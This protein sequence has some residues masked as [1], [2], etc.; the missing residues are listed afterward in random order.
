MR[1]RQEQIWLEDGQPL[2]PVLDPWQRTDFEALDQPAYQH[3]YLERPRGHS[4]TGD[5]G[6]EAVVEL[7]LGRAGQQLIAVAADE[8]QAR[9]LLDDVVAKFRRNPTLAPLATVQKNRVVMKHGGST[10][11]VLASDAPSSY[12]L[13][14]DWICCDE[15]AEWKSRGLWD[16]LWSAT[17]KRASCRVLVISTAGWDRTSI[18]WEV[19][20]I[21]ETEPNWYFS[22]RGQCASWVRPAWLAQQQRTL[23]SHVF[24]RLHENR[25]VDHVGAFLTAQ[26]VDGVFTTVPAG[27]GVYSIGCDLGLSRDRTV[28]A[29]LRVDATTGLV[30]VDQLLT[31]AP[32]LGAKVD[33]Q[34]VEAQVAAWSRAFA[35]PVVCDPWQAM[36]MSQRLRAQGV[37]VTEFTFTSETRRKLFGSL[38]DL[39][40]TG[41]LRSH[42]HDDFRRELLG[43]EVQQTAGGGW[44][45]DHRVGRHD[46]HVVATALALGAFW[47]QSGAADLAALET[48]SPEEQHFQNTVADHWG[49]ARPFAEEVA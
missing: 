28:L 10:L 36:L 14:P 40:R 12:G 7:V 43:L 25:W 30:C 29:L 19:R 9:L 32:A 34:E 22:S 37:P 8:D 45:V 24:A 20:T 3:A 6:T 35:A 18:A 23:P 15:M 11:R 33:L 31:Y 27:P 48:L 46:D 44:R 13:R 2:G 26:E 17:G 49:H 42:P 4:K 39:I 38:L 5:V 47:D 41:G 16:A 21:A 1:F